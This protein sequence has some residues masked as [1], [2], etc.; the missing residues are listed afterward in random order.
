M[1]LYVCVRVYAGTIFKQQALAHSIADRKHFIYFLKQK[2]KQ[3][4]K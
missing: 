3:I 2:Q 1:C 4:N